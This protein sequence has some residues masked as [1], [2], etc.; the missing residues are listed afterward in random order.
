MTGAAWRSDSAELVDPGA[1]RA[2]HA[3]VSARRDRRSL[4]A[5]RAGEGG[6]PDARER[7]GAGGGRARRRRPRD[8]LHGA[9]ARRRPRRQPQR[10]HLRLHGEV[11]APAAPG[12]ARRRARARDR[13]RG[14]R[15]SCSR[16]GTGSRPSRARSSTSCCA[17][18][19]CARSSASG[20]SVNVAIQNLAFDAVNASY[21][22]V[23]PRD[24][25]AGFPREYVEAVFAHTLGA[26]ATLVASADL[27]AVWRTHAM[28]APS[29]VGGRSR[30]RRS[31]PRSRNSR[32]GSGRAAHAEPRDT[33]LGQPHH[34]LAEG[35]RR[36]AA[37]AGSCPVRRA[38][39]SRRAA[40]CARSPRRTPAARGCA[41]RARR[42]DSIGAVRVWRPKAAGAGN[43]LQPWPCSAARRAARRELPPT[44][45]GGCGCWTGSGSIVFPIAGSRGPACFDARRRTRRASSR[46]SASSATSLRCSKSAP[47]A[48]TPP[49]GSR[50]RRPTITRP[51]ETASRLATAFAVE[52]G[53]AVRRARARSCAGA[54][55]RRRGGAASATNGSRA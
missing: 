1:H 18:S 40:R 14:R 37:R 42:C 22:V 16:A 47:S 11:D 43:G 44:Q 33:D 13:G 35:I 3:G 50:R 34:L 25:V 10:A 29:S 7:R 21:Q 38:R 30:F 20:V 9:A 31:A 46:R 49:P 26:V 55:A 41:A 36:R 24:A 6:A 32:P 28:P 39:S 4:R 2:R 5:A 45:S 53:V 48:R 52:E 23:I 17:T 51:P 15:T 8:P 54:G 12:L 19:A 27:L